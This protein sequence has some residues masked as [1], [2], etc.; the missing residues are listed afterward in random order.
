MINVVQ[1]LDWCDMSS[2]NFEI[3]SEISLFL[4]RPGSPTK[5]F[6]IRTMCSMRTWSSESKRRRC[7]NDGDSTSKHGER[8]EKKRERDRETTSCDYVVTTS[9]KCWV[10]HRPNGFQVAD[11]LESLQME[12]STAIQHGP[13]TRR[14]RQHG[15][16]CWGGGPSTILKHI[17]Y[18]HILCKTLLYQVIWNILSGN[19]T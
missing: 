4:T 16:S 19:Q 17:Q 8:N 7:G 9:L 15:G 6:G 2:Y 18:I 13:T 11:F 1:P 3:P 10:N 12:H 5:P 14:G